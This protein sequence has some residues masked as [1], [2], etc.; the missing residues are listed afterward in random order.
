M[1]EPINLTQLR[2]ALEDPDSSLA[3]WDMDAVVLALIDIAEAA[4]DYARTSTISREDW[5]KFKR[6]RAALTRINLET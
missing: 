5:P 1:T 4:H 3:E 2:D 6:L